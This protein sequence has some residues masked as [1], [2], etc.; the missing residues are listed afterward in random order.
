VKQR[1]VVITNAER[2]QGEQLRAR[3]IR[4]VIMM[5]T[6]LLCLIAA[7]VLVGV[8][9]PLLAV[10]LAVCVL[11]AILLP[12]LAVILANDRPPKAEHRIFNRH[13]VESEP[14]APA[15]DAAETPKV[16]DAEP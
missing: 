15:I 7:G 8:H 4:Y 3:E 6:R 14:A 10:W 1:P 12:W 13:R 11:G 5:G 2:S 9:P 16:I